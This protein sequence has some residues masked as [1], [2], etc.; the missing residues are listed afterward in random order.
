[1]CFWRNYISLTRIET[2]RPNQNPG[3]GVIRE[4]QRQWFL[5]MIIKRVP[6][7]LWDYGF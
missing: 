3:E 2:E 4:F 7:K 1:M 5:T 6:R